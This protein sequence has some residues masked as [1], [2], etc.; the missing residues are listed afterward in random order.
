MAKKSG[1]DRQTSPDVRTRPPLLETL[2][3]TADRLGIP[4]SSAHRLVTEG[5]LPSVKLGNSD[6]HW[7]RP[8]DADQLVKA[9]TS[10]RKT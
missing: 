4:Y 9:S 1:A 5:Y 2:Q 7:I 10:R 8:S 6:R 3:A